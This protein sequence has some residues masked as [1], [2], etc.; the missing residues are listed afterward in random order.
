MGNQNKSLKNSHWSSEE[1]QIQL[2]SSISIFSS[3]ICIHLQLITKEKKS[4]LRNY[5]ENNP[6]TMNL[7]KAKEIERASLV[8]SLSKS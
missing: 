4:N 8:T 2:D 1:I 6:S 7:S 3:V 5:K